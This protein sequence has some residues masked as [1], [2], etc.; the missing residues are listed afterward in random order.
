MM[1]GMLFLTKYIKGIVVELV[2]NDYLKAE[3]KK[4]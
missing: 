1:G 2:P 3:F 4:Y